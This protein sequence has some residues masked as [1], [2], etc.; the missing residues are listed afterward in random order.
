[1][2]NLD[3]NFGNALFHFRRTG[4]PRGFLWKFT[5]SFALLTLILQA[6]SIWLQWPI[7]EIYLRILRDGGEFS[8]HISDLEAVSMRSNITG[9]LFAPI[10]VLGWLMFETASQR[11]YMRAEGFGLRIG[12]DE[13]RVLIVGLMWMALYIAAYIALIPVIII[14]IVVAAV[15]GQS[16]LPVVIILS[17]IL[18][19]A[20][21]LALLWFSARF[22]AASALTIRDRQ[23]RFFESWAVTRNKGWTIV[24]TWLVAFAALAFGFAVLLCVVVLAGASFVDLDWPQEEGWTMGFSQFLL[25]LYR[26]SLG[27]LLAIGIAGSAATLVQGIFQH[28]FGGAA[29]LAARTDPNWLGVSGVSSTFS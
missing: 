17:I 22:S 15:G 1:M 11:R 8:R 25:L 20:Y 16:A 3:F 7:Y 6:F 27:A 26:T 12:A 18:G 23:I 13:G 4:G 14:V 28:I 2:P 5:L 21:I 9:L 24:G 10:G 19:L 29:A